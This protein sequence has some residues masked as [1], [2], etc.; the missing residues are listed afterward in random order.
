M[1]MNRRIGI[2]TCLLLVIISGAAFADVQIDSASFPDDNFRK[3]VEAF[4]LDHDGKL[5]SD[6]IAV[7]TEMDCSDREISSIRGIEFFP[8]LKEL[9]CRYNTLKKIDISR[10][11]NLEALYCG[12]NQ[13][14]RL[15]VS[16]NTALKELY[17]GSN[18]IT[19]L[20]VRKNVSLAELACSSNPLS[21]LDVSKNTALE[22][23]YCCNIGLKELDVSH[24]PQLRE[25]YC[26]GNELTDLNLNK[27]TKITS[28]YCYHNKIKE[29]DLSHVVFLKKHV[30]QYES[31]TDSG[32]IYWNGGGT[33]EPVLEVDDTVRIIAGPVD[34][35]A[36]TIKMDD[37]HEYTGKAIKPSAAVLYNDQK[38]KKG[39][40]YTVSYRNNKKIGTATITI[41]G[42]G[43]YTGTVSANFT[44]LPRAVEITSLTAGKG[45]LEIEWEK[46]STATGYEIIYGVS[47]DA[48]NA[49]IRTVT[50][51]TKVILDGLKPKTKYYVKVVAFKT[52]GDMDY[53]SSYSSVKSK[54]TK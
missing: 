42:K 28:L 34:I 33:G 25:L 6:E 40:D 43:A 27:S 53:Y 17:C 13:L 2:L 4:D 32:V 12:N 16:K 37:I 11:T 8:S 48:N 3:C 39:R 22:D 1:N 54:R 26:Y 23:L 24:N 31:S 51:K 50:G 36:A 30:S 47:P 19:S 15:N 41:K 45:Q 52:V 14:T 18:Q 29:I 46:S 44:I 49:M 21:G 5:N 9:D 7:V 35:G 20:N 38:L 10:N